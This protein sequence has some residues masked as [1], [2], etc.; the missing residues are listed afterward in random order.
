MRR[1]ASL[2]FGVLLCS[3]TL[4]TGVTRAEEQ[5][6]E[7][8]WGS[9]YPAAMQRAQDKRTMMFVY[10]RG[11]GENVIRDRFENV[12]LADQ[13]VSEKLA[14]LEAVRL[15]LDATITVG[16][17]LLTVLEHD[18]FSELGGKEGIAIIDFTNPDAPQYGR[19]VTAI[20]FA[21][22]KY[23]QFQPE[24]LKV[25]LDLPE[26]TIT[27]RTLVFAVRIHPEGP[28]STQGELD[29]TLA[30]HAAEHSQHQADIRVQGH[31][32][33]GQR[34]HRISALLP[35]GLRLQEVVAES[36]PQE[37]LV[38]AAVDCVDSWRHS[39]GHW[40]AVRSWQPRFGY[41]MRR[42]SNGIWYATGLFGNR[43]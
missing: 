34:F 25:I 1:W 24:H 40:S 16:G 35:G 7:I 15:P 42:G 38:D 9:Q 5:V 20:P 41:D 23:Y 11:E 36:W 12:A 28:K 17:E 31:H 18:A 8:R 29:A 43:N 4:A 10:F 27:Q 26:G 2:W 13:E 3:A 39:S 21:R 19:V 14:K 32:N 30:N 6:N 22:G 37:N 33:F